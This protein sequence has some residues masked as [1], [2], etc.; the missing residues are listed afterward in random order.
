MPPVSFLIAST[1]VALTALTVTG[2]ATMSE[3]DCR[4]AHWESVGLQDGLEGASAKRLDGHREACASTG[5]VPDTVQWRRG[6]AHGLRSYCT[7]NSAWNVGLANQTY[8]GVCGHLD[9][10]TFLRYHRAGVLVWQA[11]QE[12]SRSRA[13]LTRLETDLKKAATEGER[14]RL[15]DEIDRAE[16]ELSRLTTLVAVLQSAG[17]SR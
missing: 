3:Q 5:V 11:R 7:P 14:R 8:H 10:P 1:V 12:L 4:H 16:R 15:N 9:E 17:P 13:V 6:Y 2:C